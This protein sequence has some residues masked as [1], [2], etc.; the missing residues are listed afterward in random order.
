MRK[1]LIIVGVAFAVLL[2][3][4]GGLFLYAASNLNSIIASNRG[5]IRAKL[6]DSAGRQVE[7]QEIKAALGWGVTLDVSGVKIADDPAFSQRPF[8]EAGSLSGEVAFLPLLSRN[9]EIK[10]LVFKKPAVRILRERDGRLNV[11]TLGKKEGVA[12]AAPPP[13][14]AGK[15]GN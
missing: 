10:R 1:I 5:F 4:I 3:V 9:V 14:P 11:A 13:A 15:L 6:S 2:L 7:A 8:L 12:E